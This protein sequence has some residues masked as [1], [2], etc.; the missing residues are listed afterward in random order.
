MNISLRNT[1]IGLMVVFATSTA[2][3]QVEVMFSGAG[4]ATFA[5]TEND[6]DAAAVA[7]DAALGTA[8]SYDLTVTTTADILLFDATLTLAGGT[9]FV[10]DDTFTAITD[11]GLGSDTA[12]PQTALLG[13]FPILHADSWVTTPDSG[14]SAAGTIKL[15]SGMKATHFD[16][17][18]GPA[19]T[20][21]HFA[22]IVLLPGDDGIQATLTGQVQTAADPTPNFDDFVYTF[23]GVVPEPASMGLVF[24]ALLG[25]LA[26]IRRKRN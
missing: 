8:K 14:T 24:T 15:S 21:F 3:A 23:G 10:N 17:V 20:D 4:A 19:V 26:M 12:P 16:T 1:V 22:R 11:S 7:A 9:Q 2:F 13:A 18:T 5:G 6:V 25:G